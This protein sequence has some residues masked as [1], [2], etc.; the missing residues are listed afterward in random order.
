MLRAPTQED[1]IFHDEMEELAS[2][3][4]GRVHLLVGSRHKVRLDHRLFGRL[5]PDI[6]ERDVYVCG[7]EGFSDRILAAA[8]R[9]GVGADAIHTESFAF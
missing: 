5:V 6:A 4:G 2:E 1:V 3:R 7:P 9:L 8:R